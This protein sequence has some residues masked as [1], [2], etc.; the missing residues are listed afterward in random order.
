MVIP[1]RRKIAK[2]VSAKNRRMPAATQQ[3]NRAMRIRSSGVFVAVIARKAG[4]VPIESTMTNN[5]EKASRLYAP[6]FM[7][8]LSSRRGRRLSSGR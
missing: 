4:M 1:K 6:R 3:A 2:P 7:A 8:Q 5:D